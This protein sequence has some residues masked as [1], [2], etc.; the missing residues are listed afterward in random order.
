MAIKDDGRLAVRETLKLAWGDV[1]SHWKRGLALLLLLYIPTILLYAAGLAKWLFLGNAGPWT[2]M[3]VALLLYLA[4]LLF[5]CAVYV[6]F[7]R[8]FLVGPRY[9]FRIS[10]GQLARYSLRFLWKMVQYF[11]MVTVV[12]FVLLVPC[13]ILLAIL[14]VAFQAGAVSTSTAVGWLAFLLPLAVWLVTMALHLVLAV[15][16][17]PTFFGTTV[18]QIIRFRES[19][20]TMD[21]YTWRTILALVP[22]ML[23][24]IVSFIIIFIVMLRGMMHSGGNMVAFFESS[25]D[26]WW[27]WLV[28][29]P[30]TYISYGWAV[31][32]LSQLYRDMWPAPAM[33][34]APSHTEEP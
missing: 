6:L 23:I 34:D 29:L 13:M 1:M 25:S 9:V 20:R 11:L 8:L 28:T 17:Y 33:L 10:A 26:L 16:L 12:L 14:G 31:G 15:R 21:G 18:G 30:V 19:W 2:Q 5:S 22:P 27:V 3:L 24:M 32:V 4:V 7:I